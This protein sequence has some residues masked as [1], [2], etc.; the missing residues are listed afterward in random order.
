MENDKDNF[1]IIEKLNNG[2][3]IIKDGRNIFNLSDGK[4]TL[5]D[6]DFFD[7]IK[8]LKIWSELNEVLLCRKNLKTINRNSSVRE[9]ITTYG[10]RIYTIDGIFLNQNVSNTEYLTII[11]DNNGDPIFLSDEKKNTIFNLTQLK[12]DIIKKEKIKRKTLK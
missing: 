4:N 12:K 9:S 5:L 11:Y 7:D 10:Y 8:I 1:E 2:L 3:F 6:Y